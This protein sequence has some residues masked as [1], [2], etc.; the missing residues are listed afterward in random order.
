MK[1][2]ALKEKSKDDLRHIALATAINIDYIVSWNFKHFVDI[3]TINKVTAINKL[4][5]YKE[6]NILPP[7]MIISY[8]F[9]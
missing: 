4:L 7:S 3:N 6:I 8:N 1:Y 9:V 2:G 5:N